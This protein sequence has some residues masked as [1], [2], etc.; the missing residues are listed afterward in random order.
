[1]RQSKKRIH[2]SDS[3]PEAPPTLVTVTKSHIM[4][5]PGT[6]A[7]VATDSLKSIPD[8]FCVKYLP[9]SSNLSEKALQKGL[10]YFTQGYI[11]D[12]KIFNSDES[13][14]AAARCWRSMRKNQSPHRLHLE[15]KNDSINESHCSCKVGYV[16]NKYYK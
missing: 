12:I 16:F 4:A 3:P 15:I 5:M 10:N 2:S 14:Q 8:D 7:N 1:M 9:N 6:S 13:V 11:H